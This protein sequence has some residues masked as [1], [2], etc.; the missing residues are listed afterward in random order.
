MRRISSYTG[1]EQEI[2]GEIREWSRHALENPNEEYGG[3][4]ACS[5]AKKAWEEDKVGFSFK[6]SPGYQP[7]YS[8]IS[9]FDDVHDVVIL[10]DLIYEKSSR[11]FVGIK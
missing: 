1:L 2:C 9:M 8:L 3:L 5:Y 6:Y 4:P 10:V 7:L 11:V